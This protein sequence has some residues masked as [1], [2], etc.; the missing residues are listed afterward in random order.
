MPCG[1][2]LHAALSVHRIAEQRRGEVRRRRAEQVVRHALPGAE[3]RD[4][5]ARHSRSTEASGA[6]DS[7]SSSFVRTSRSGIGRRRGARCRRDTSRAELPAGT[8]RCVRTPRALR[9]DAR[10]ARARRRRAANGRRCRREPARARIDRARDRDRPRERAASERRADD[11]GVEPQLLDGADAEAVGRHEPQPRAAPG[12]L[13]RRDLGDGRRLAGAGRADEHLHR[14]VARRPPRRTA[15]P[16]RLTATRT[17]S[18]LALRAA[19]DP[20]RPASR[21]ERRTG[22][23]PAASRRAARRLTCSR[24]GVGLSDFLPRRPG[25]R[26]FALDG[27]GHFDLARTQTSPRHPRAG[28]SWVESTR[29]SG[30]SSARAPRQRVSH[31][32][33]AESLQMHV[34]PAP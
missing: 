22:A 4:L 13:L 15:Q 7:A 10:T 18:A 24:S 30:P 31:S 20:S 5:A 14:R 32:L 19:F 16:T 12:A 33:P 2:V 6:S 27:G 21:R 17:A 11:V 3:V 26:H 28:T 1:L 34:T 8:T 29:A 23:N 9:Q 25:F